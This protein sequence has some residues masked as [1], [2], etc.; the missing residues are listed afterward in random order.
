MKDVTG[1]AK[2]TKDGPRPVI[3]KFLDYREKTNVLS[4]AFKLKGST[5][6]LSEDFSKRIR[7]IRKQLWKSSEEERLRGCK[8]KLVYDKLKVDNVL[9]AWD[10]G[11]GSRYRLM[12][13]SN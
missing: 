5:L 4:S 2:K 6:S 3:I 13:K 12:Q 7:E 10:E 8:T 9:F 11:K 1:L